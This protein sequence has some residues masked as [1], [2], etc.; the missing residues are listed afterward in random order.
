MTPPLLPVPAISQPGSLDAFISVARSQVGYREAANNSNV[1]G[2]LYGLDHQP[3]CG[4]FVSWVAKAAGCSKLVPRFAYT[5]SGAHWFESRDQWG[6]APK[7]GAVMFVF[8]AS[9]GRIGHTGIVVK[10]NPDGSFVSVEGNGLPASERVLTP[11]GWRPIGSL[12]VGDGIVDP[13]GS[14]SA[15]TGVFPQGVRPCYKLTLSDGR[16]IVADDSHRWLVN[17]LRVPPRVMTT[18]EIRETLPYRHMAL[19]LIAV[20]PDLAGRDDLPADPWLIGV[21]LGDGSTTEGWARFSSGDDWMVARVEALSGVTPK[22]HGGNTWHLPGLNHLA[23]LPGLHGCHAWEKYIPQDYLGGSYKDRLAL[24]RG[25]MDTDGDC[26]KQGRAAFNTTSRVLAEQ[27]RDLVYSLGGIASLETRESPRYNRGGT[28]RGNVRIGRTSYRVGNI[29]MEDNPFTRPRKATR[30]VAMHQRATIRGRRIVSVE[31]VE[32]TETVCIA[33]SAPS[34]L[35]VAGD[36]FVTHNSSNTGS[37]QG[38]GV[39]RLKR[40][41][42]PAGSG[43]G[44]PKW[45]AAAHPAPEVKGP[46]NL[47]KVIAKAK[48]GEPYDGRVGAALKAEGLTADRAGYRAWQMKLGYRGPDADGLAGAKSLAKLGAKHGFAVDA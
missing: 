42:L 3:W 16:T 24:L 37:R 5:P 41:S 9:M 25:L 18:S 33:V 48:A 17:S 23:R 7:L 45:P 20:P 12:A 30:F 1:F 35:Y 27:T 14:P 32:P 29:R 22:H 47:A 34:A 4:A 36:W 10:V 31:P 15:V 38:D 44:Y 11:N 39:Y 2:A 26:D 13:N 19:P 28:D 8:H 43:F 21:L 6:H 40:A 46:V